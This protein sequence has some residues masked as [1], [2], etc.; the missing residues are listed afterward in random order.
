LAFFGGEPFALS[1]V[2]LCLVDSLAKRFGRDVKITSY[3]RHWIPLVGGV[4]KPDGFL[5]ELRRVEPAPLSQLFR[6]L[7]Q[8]LIA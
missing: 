3:L 6:P 5:L 1:G 2:D 7:S 8:N 4:N